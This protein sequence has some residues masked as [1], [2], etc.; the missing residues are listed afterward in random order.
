MYSLVVVHDGHRL[1]EGLHPREQLWGIEMCTGSARQRETGAGRAYPPSLEA[2]CLI[3][4]FREWPRTSDM[5]RMWWRLS[6]K[7][8]VGTGTPAFWH[9]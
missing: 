4:C 6:T 7:R 1:A 2:A 5:K 9:R 3:V 8:S